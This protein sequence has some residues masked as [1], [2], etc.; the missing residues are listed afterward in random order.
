[1]LL[2]S[3][4]L[5]YPWAN[6]YLFFF[7]AACL[8]EKQHNPISHTCDLQHSRPAHESLQHWCSLYFINLY[9]FEKCLP[10]VYQIHVLGDVLWELLLQVACSMCI[11]SIK[12][13]CWNQEVTIQRIFFNFYWSNNTIV[14]SINTH[15]TQRFHCCAWF[16]IHLCVNQILITRQEIPACAYIPPLIL[17]HIYICKL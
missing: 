1:M 11:Q 10:V 5:F 9:F 13:I 17:P 15:F 2:H 14:L 16:I 3:D 12:F 6:Q 4:K 8:A 7:D